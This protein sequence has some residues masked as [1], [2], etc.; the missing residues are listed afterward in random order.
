MNEHLF[1]PQSPRQ[2]LSNTLQR[3]DGTQPGRRPDSPFAGDSVLHLELHVDRHRAGVDAGGVR[4]IAELRFGRRW[5]RGGVRDALARH[6]GRGGRR[7]F[8]C[9]A[10]VHFLHVVLQ[11]VQTLTE[12]LV[13]ILVH[14]YKMR[15]M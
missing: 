10:L 1:I 5:R 8:V 15:V 2:L 4:L 9:P 3:H 12:E 7:C 11:L 13:S 6:G 14:E